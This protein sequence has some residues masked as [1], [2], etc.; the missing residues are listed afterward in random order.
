MLQYCVFNSY[1]LF[2]HL[3]VMGSRSP[4]VGKLDVDFQVAIWLVDGKNFSLNSV[5]KIE[6][7]LPIPKSRLIVLFL[8]AWE[9]HD[10]L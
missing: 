9:Q 2:C 7:L 5:F 10:K 3:D 1:T 6:N 4:A 8:A